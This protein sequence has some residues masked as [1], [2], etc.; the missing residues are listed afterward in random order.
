MYLPRL[1]EETESLF[2]LRQ[3]YP[4]LLRLAGTRFSG[5]EQKS[6]KIKALDKIMRYGILNGFSHASEYAK[7]AELLT[8]QVIELINVMGIDVAK[9]LKVPSHPTSVLCRIADL[10]TR[11][12]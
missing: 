10:S 11:T 4:A 9:H 5:L 8:N 2:L 1:T 6:S 3:A 7:I 12:F